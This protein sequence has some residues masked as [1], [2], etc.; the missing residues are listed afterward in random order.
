MLKLLKVKLVPVCREAKGKKMFKHRKPTVMLTQLPG[1]MAE[2]YIDFYE[3]WSQSCTG[4]NSDGSQIIGFDNMDTENPKNP[5]DMFEVVLHFNKK[6]RI[7][8][9]NDKKCWYG[10]VQSEASWDRSH[11]YKRFQKHPDKRQYIQLGR[12]R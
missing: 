5:Y 2:L 8:G 3:R 9:H 10:I 11:N 12:E 7:I 6:V 4:S 1:G